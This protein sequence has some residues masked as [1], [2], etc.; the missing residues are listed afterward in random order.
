MSTELKHNSQLLDCAFFFF[1]VEN[2]VVN[3]KGDN[4]AWVFWLL[5]LTVFIY[6]WLCWILVAVC[7]LSLIVV[8]RGYSLIAVLGLLIAVASLISEHGH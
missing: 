1:S 7:R 4:R 2:P 3:S 5:F 8:S 6:F